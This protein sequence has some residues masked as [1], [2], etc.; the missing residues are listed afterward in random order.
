MTNRWVGDTPIKRPLLFCRWNCWNKFCIAALNFNNVF[1]WDSWDRNLKGCVR[2]L[3]SHYEEKK[4]LKAFKPLHIQ[5]QIPIID[6][7]WVSLSLLFIR[8]DWSVFTPPHPTPP[9]QNK[10]KHTFTFC[11]NCW[12]LEMLLPEGARK[13]CWNHISQFW[14]G[15]HW[16]KVQADYTQ[17]T[18]VAIRVKSPCGWAFSVLRVVQCSEKK[19]ASLLGPFHV[20]FA[21]STRSSS[22]DSSALLWLGRRWHWTLKWWRGHKWLFVGFLLSVL[23]VVWWFTGDMRFV[24]P[25]GI[26]LLIVS[27]IRLILLALLHVLALRVGL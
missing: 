6:L 18:Q 12:W 20:R 21:C 13:S 7:G 23:G 22:L 10:Q 1:C 24:E 14:L 17:N 16:Q 4:V 11:V 25:L 26:Q 3:L 9:Q 5:E 8:S 19:W 15:A 2:G 27:L